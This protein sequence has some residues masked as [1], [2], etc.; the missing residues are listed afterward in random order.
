MAEQSKARTVF[1]SATRT[2]ESWVRMPLEAWMCVRVFLC[3]V[4]LYCI[5]I[6]PIPHP[7]NVPTVQHIC[8]FQ[9]INSKPKQAKRPNPW[10]TTITTA[11]AA[12]VI[13]RILTFIPHSHTRVRNFVKNSTQTF[14][15]LYFA[16]L[17][18]DSR[19]DFF[20]ARSKFSASSSWRC[21]GK[22]CY[23]IKRGVTF[24]S[25]SLRPSPYTFHFLS[26]CSQFINFSRA[27]SECFWS[28]GLHQS[29][30]RAWFSCYTQICFVCYP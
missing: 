5:C 9:K 16:I 3:C 23:C 19:K 11:A 15:R 20:Q 2:L 24:A 21:V 6:G 22:A 7:R 26:Q 4:V 12:A 25:P 13:V 17:H 18:V 14:T 30:A 1:S 10:K 27:F 8:K 29:D 28:T